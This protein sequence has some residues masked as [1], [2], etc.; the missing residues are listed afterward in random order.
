[1]PLS[2]PLVLSLDPGR[3]KPNDG[4]NWCYLLLGSHSGDEGYTAGHIFKKG[5]QKSQDSYCHSQKDIQHPANP[6]CHSYHVC[7][8][9]P[10]D[11]SLPRFGKHKLCIMTTWTWIKLSCA[12]SQVHIHVAAT[13]ICGEVLELAHFIDLGRSISGRYRHWLRYR[14]SPKRTQAYTQRWEMDHPPIYFAINS[15]PKWKPL[16]S[17]I[18]NGNHLP[19]TTLNPLNRWKPR[20]CNGTTCRFCW[21]RGETSPKTSSLGGTGTRISARCYLQR[22]AT[23]PK[24][25]GCWTW[26]G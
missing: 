10:F 15:S 4:P 2:S 23:T 5:A 19:T 12:T 16:R 7:L 13:P 11:I 9:C 22:T 14:Y 8:F 6:F 26:Q 20:R 25:V 1:M 3:A 18:S 24:K 21:P 17:M